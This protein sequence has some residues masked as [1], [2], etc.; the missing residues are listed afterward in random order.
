MQL[1]TPGVH[2]FP[3]RG[4]SQI[5]VLF[6]NT[7][8]WG[9]DLSFCFAK[10]TWWRALEHSPTHCWF[11]VANKHKKDQGALFHSSSHLWTPSAKLQSTV[12][13][14]EHRWPVPPTWRLF[15]F[16]GDCRTTFSSVW[17]P[18]LCRPGFLTVRKNQPHVGQWE[19]FG[20]ASLGY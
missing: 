2:Y 12:Q 13:I 10:K 6:L 19:V 5:L 8:K 15:L 16:L 1:C 18:I 20:L 11:L 17:F 7:Q 3:Q 9:S 4:Q 14:V